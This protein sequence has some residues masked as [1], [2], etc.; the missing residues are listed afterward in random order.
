MSTAMA[1]RP[2]RT[3]AILRA[4][5]LWSV[6]AIVVTVVAANAL[7]V[8]GVHTAEP[9]VYFSGL[10]HP[11]PG[12]AKGVATIDP[13]VGWTVE[14]LGRSA[15]RSWLNGHVP[16]W[17][18]H[19]GVGTPLAGEMQSAA[20]FLPFVLLLALPQGVLLMH[21][22]L[23][24]I[25]GIGTLLFLRKLGLG[26]VAATVGG[27]LFAVNGAFAVMTNAPFNPI[28]FLPF[29]LWGVELVAAAIR[30]GRTP[31]WGTWTIALSLV[32]MLFAGFPETALLEGLFLAGWTIARLLTLP[33]GRARFFGWVVAGGGL[34]ILIS[35]PV[36]ITFAH[37]LGFGFTAYHDG[38]AAAGAYP[39]KRLSALAM[40]FA[41]GPLGRTVAGGQA[42]FVTLAAV[43]LAGIGFLG[44]R[45]R[46]VRWIIGIG[47]ALLLLNQYGAPPINQ[48]AGRLPGLNQILLYKYGVCLV[49]FAVILFA[50][51]GIDDLVRRRARRRALAVGIGFAVAY[52]IASPLYVHIALGSLH[53]P[54][55]SAVVLTWTA[56]ICLAV[57][58]LAVLSR[59]RRLGR[60]L[61]GV[62]AALVV[63]D[64]AA[65]YSVPSIA[66]SPPV[67][68]DL[69]PVRYLQQHLGT[70]RFYTLGPIQPNYGSYFGIAQLNIND[71]PVPKK[72]ADFI[73][74]D[75]RPEPGTPG[76]VEGSKAT[77]RAYSPY[78]LTYNNYRPEQQ[79]LL[80]KAYGQEQD[81]FRDAAVE[82]VVMAPNVNDAAARR[83][84]LVKVFQNET[85]AIWRDP[86]ALPYYTTLGGNC[87]VREQSYT[88]VTV[89]CARPATLVR[90]QLSSPGWTVTVNGASRRIPDNGSLFSS[91]RLPAGTSRVSYDYLPD[92]FVPAA[93]ISLGTAALLPLDLLIGAVRRRRS[94]H[95]SQR[96]SRHSTAPADAPAAL[97]N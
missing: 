56:V 44:P 66:A 54:R 1:G 57:A 30:E 69:A 24:L 7:Y 29:S 16:L 43:L 55:W 25:A 81:H 47:T 77:D 86:K 11:E 91:I 63:V 32:F 96:A 18:V 37:F 49:E 26:W 68:V 15:A 33:A 93:V 23:E 35:L 34:A 2:S 14:A 64:G 80:L 79:R 61:L 82:Y 51:Y 41:T 8:F 28:A 87:R 6:L 92:H 67:T 85:A 72:M 53:H 83:L 59:R 52:L 88:A 27:C 17:N 62:L 21:L 46:P 48:I 36:L 3:P 38:N 95:A 5:A 60:G 39:V 42:G 89:D 40:P 71:L 94:R 74:A 73:T 65:N 78:L 22:S 10:A 90:R 13:N 70:S 20:F 19:E 12:L 9:M 97:R 76:A 4:P 45:Q 50:A 58:A 84:G 31:R 75:L